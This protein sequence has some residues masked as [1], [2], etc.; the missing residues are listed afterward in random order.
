MHP[1]AIC[2]NRDNCRMMN[3]LEGS[4]LIWQVIPLLI[5]FSKYL[6]T[7][8]RRTMSRGGDGGRVSNSRSRI[9]Q[10]F[11]ELVCLEV[12]S[13]PRQI[14]YDSRIKVLHLITRQFYLIFIIIKIYLSPIILLIHIERIELECGFSPFK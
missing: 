10:N 2:S 14:I 6:D 1:R 9:D 12:V 8:P 7:Y 11:V 3:I 13:G 4:M 5:L